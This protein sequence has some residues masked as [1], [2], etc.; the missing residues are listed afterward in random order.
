MSKYLISRNNPF[1]L[2]DPFFD[3]FFEKENRGYSLMKT[4]ITDEGDHYLMKIDLPE[5]KKDDIKISLKDGSL[6]ISAEY[7]NENNQKDKHGKYICRE[8]HYGTY[9]RSYYVGDNV[10]FEDIKA[11]LDN[12]VL[13]L[14]IAKKEAKEDKEDEYIAIE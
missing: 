3:D 13:T 4:D 12:G 6:T 8:R 9:S 5:V 1:G 7:N 10:K 14:T 2:I 11:K